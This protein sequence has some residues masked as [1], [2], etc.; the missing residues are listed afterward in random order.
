MSE[1]K[2]VVVLGAS[3]GCPAGLIALMVGALLDEKDIAKER[4]DFTPVEIY[5]Y[6]GPEIDVSRDARSM[7]PPHARQSKGERKRNKRDRWR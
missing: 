7:L 1:S 5:L 6:D 3:S 2:R 4:G